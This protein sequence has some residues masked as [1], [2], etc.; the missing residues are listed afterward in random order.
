M[1]TIYQNFIGYGKQWIDQDDIDSV[2]NV[3][4]SE[5]I[6]QGEKVDYFEE[7]LCSLTEAKHA[8]VVSNG[9]AALHLTMLALNIGKEDW[10]ITTPNTFIASSNAA[11]FC[12]GNVS[13][14]DIDPLTYLISPQALEDHLKSLQKKGRKLPKAIVN[15]LFAGS[16][17]NI[18]DIFQI[19]KKYNITVIEDACHAVGGR[20]Q[21]S[22]RRVGCGQFADF[23]IFSFHPVKH[24]T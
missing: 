19:A 3:L 4:K 7:S 15:V 17:S 18:K 12:D 11:L 9:T 5:M 13:F 20:Y 24:I 14:V 16:S 10:I 21:E 22:G 2:V 6:T 23:T 8:I 1:Q